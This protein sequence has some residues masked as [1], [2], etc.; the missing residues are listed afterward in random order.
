MAT[1]SADIKVVPTGTFFKVTVESGSIGTAQETIKHIYNPIT[2]HNL[3]EVRGNHSSSG[4]DFSSVG[5]TGV[6]ASLIAIVW[7]LITFTPWVLMVFLGGFGT[8]VGEKITGMSVEEYSNS[9][10]DHGHKRMVFILIL[11][12]LAGG[13]G[14]V[15]GHHIQNSDTTNVEV[16]K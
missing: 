11:A 10:E 15:Q 9:G 16:T 3:R 14:F 7:L 12:L 5:S 1:Y 2:I 13:F 6:F 4:I 8:W